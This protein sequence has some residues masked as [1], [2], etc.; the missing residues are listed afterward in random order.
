MT[1]L[2]RPVNGPEER[3]TMKGLAWYSDGKSTFTEGDVVFV[4]AGGID[5]RTKLPR[6]AECRVVKVTR[7]RVRLQRVH[8]ETGM[9]RKHQE[10][11][12]TREQARQ[13]A[14]GNVLLQERP[15]L[16]A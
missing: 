3:E 6:V 5:H 15:V 16:R 8:G 7:G 9:W 12:R 10:C 14:T 13:D 1:L 4:A 2:R 11:H